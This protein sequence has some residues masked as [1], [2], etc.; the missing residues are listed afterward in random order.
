MTVHELCDSLA[1]VCSLCV[2]IENI[3]EEKNI[4]FMGKTKCMCLQGASTNRLNE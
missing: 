3:Y 1:A 2:S 4:N